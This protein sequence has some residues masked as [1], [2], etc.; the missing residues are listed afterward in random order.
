[1]KKIIL[2]IFVF[3]FICVNS[4]AQYNEEDYQNHRQKNE[5]RDFIPGKN[6]RRLEYK[7]NR[8]EPAKMRPHRKN[9]GRRHDKRMMEI[10]RKIDKL[11]EAKRKEA[12]EEMKRHHQKM[13]E[14][15]GEEIPFPKFQ[16]RK[17]VSNKGA[18]KEGRSK[19]PKIISSNEVRS[20]VVVEKKMDQP[21]KDVAMEDEV[22]N[23]NISE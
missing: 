4:Y 5:S 17:K 9:R 14:I 11:P 21:I 13:S 3:S 23:V 6:Q 1:M 15:I 12:H 7:L 16:D 2:S 8:G 19:K 18:A 10:K 22:Q 20:T